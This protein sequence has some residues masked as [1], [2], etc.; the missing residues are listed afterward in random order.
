MSFLQPWLLAALPLVALP[1][2][3]HLIHQ[4]RY[5]TTQWAAM[6][7]LLA[8]KGMSRGY[9]RLRRWLIMSARIAVIAASVLAVSRPL[10]SGW[11][12]LLGGGR[13]DT[14]I[15]LLDRSP[16]MQARQTPSDPG[17]LRRA[18]E[19]LAETLR[20]LG[21]SS[22]LV[23]IDSVAAEPRE[24]ESAEAMLDS[25][26]VDA[27]ANSADIPAML[28]AARD[29]IRL[30]NPGRTDVWIAS[31]LQAADWDPDSARWQTLR[32]D[33]QGFPQAVRFHLLSL[34]RP[35]PAGQD[36]TLPG[37]PAGGDN[38]AIRVEQTRRVE[39]EQAA[40]LWLAL[41]LIGDADGTPGSPPADG[42]PVTL[43]V[44]VEIE[45][46]RTVT[47]VEWR[48]TDSEPVE[49]RLPLRAG[50]RRGWG[51]VTIPAD[52]NPADNRFY[53][54]F[55]QP[56]PRR[57]A[58]VSDDAAVAERLRL[59]AAASKDPQPQDV[60]E[61][62]PPRRA[63]TLPWEEM[64]L[65]LWHADLP[66]GT[67]ADEFMN[68][69]S[70]G[71][72]AI[73]FPPAS[74]TGETFLGARWGVWSEERPPARVVT[75][76]NDQDLWANTAVGTALPVGELEIRRWAALEGDVTPLASLAEDRP[77]LARVLQGAG[78][79]YFCG[80]GPAADESTLAGDGVV[81][82][83]MVQRALA[84]GTAARGKSLQRDAGTLA[85]ELAG[86]PAEWKRLA[87]DEG[88]SAEYPY[89]AGVYRVEDRML[90]INRP[91]GEDDSARITD[92]RCD[93][94]FDGL[95][96]VRVDLDV[97]SGGGLV[98]EVWRLFVIAMVSA[99]ILE[100]GLSLPRRGQ[101][102]DR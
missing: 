82:Y 44:T 63:A 67:A 64:S 5:R 86:A 22:R 80:T 70:R 59:A 97:A 7:F 85:Q 31:D 51:V 20:T 41:R 16:S 98:Q 33:F 29:Y 9:A 72:R 6:M 24:W 4:R 77:I 100:A 93:T 46:V 13:S 89:Q 79:A 27:A 45:G 78:A 71:G 52:A 62:V 88:T 12:G 50:Q 49:L 84:A 53:F 95:D 58:I 36:E 69:L 87:G 90:A 68:F 76:R 26:A 61:V 57:T 21:G 47:R 30:N 40:E 83:V 74:P 75:W 38:M 19:R 8:A 99:M 1:V 55:D 11:L 73:F 35:Q 3:I 34:A 81:F 43:P 28:A 25:P 2:I 10:S 101:L 92:E 17:K 42:E 18:S 15:V 66:T 23:V 54:V 39:T 102:G 48:G 60:A 94:L 56:P 32:D 14:T 65:V 96:F 91:P 37:R